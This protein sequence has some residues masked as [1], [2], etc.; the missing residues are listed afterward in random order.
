MHALPRPQAVLF[1]LDG[2]LLDSAPDLAGAVHV[3]QNARGVALTDYAL[4]RVQA[5]KGARGL[6]GAAFGID[7]QDPQWP[8]MRDEFL[9]IYEQAMAVRSCLFPG[10]PELLDYLQQQ[11]IAWGVVTNKL[12]R[13]TD[14][15]LPQVGLGHAACAISGDSTAHPKPHPAPLLEAVRRLELRPAD[16]WYAGDDAR[17]IEAARAAG[18]P[19]LAAAWGYCDAEEIPHWNATH[20]LQSAGELT[21][22]LRQ[23]AQPA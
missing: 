7:N 9:R 5:S 1:D 16:C 12:A 15:L 20:I 22:L 3:M 21:T 13:F 18:M 2:T 17:D 4:L 8:A 11:G 6:L 10:V 23:C 19:G 14:A